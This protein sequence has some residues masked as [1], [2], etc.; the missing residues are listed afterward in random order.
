[1]HDKSV[2]DTQVCPPTNSIIINGPI[3]EIKLMI[4]SNKV[5]PF[6]ITAAEFTA[7]T[8]RSQAGKWIYINGI[9]VSYHVVFTTICLQMKKVSF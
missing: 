8:M 5:E 1:M 4:T 9:A 6:L 7:S 2:A 3:K